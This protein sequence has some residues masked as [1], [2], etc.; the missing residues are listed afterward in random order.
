MRKLLTLVFA[1]LFVP[2]ALSAQ[3]VPPVRVTRITDQQAMAIALKVVGDDIG[4]NDLSSWGDPHVTGLSR[5]NIK[6]AGVL[7]NPTGGTIAVGVSSPKAAGHVRVLLNAATGAVMSKRVGLSWDWGN[8]PAWWKSG[9][10]SPP[11]A[12]AVN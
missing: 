11:P 4:K 10:N 3:K 2:V 1:T 12:R 6:V 5:A 8:A 7:F 9:A